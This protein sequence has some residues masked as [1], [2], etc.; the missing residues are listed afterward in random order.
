[1]GIGHRGYVGHHQPADPRGGLLGDLHGDLAAHGVTDYRHLIQR[2]MIQQG[3]H[4]RRL[5]RVAH[6]VRVKGGTMIAQVQADDP[7]VFTE[8]AGQQ[9]EIV[10]AA[11]QA[12]DQDD[13]R[14]LALFLEM[15]KL[16]VLQNNT[17][18]VV[19]CF[20]RFLTH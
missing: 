19:G 16:I 20:A 9:A 7:A 6:L 15:Q 3:D 8:R 18:S 11:E 10:Q 2:Q 1:M 12:V 17:L 5:L 14:A 4:I 13:G